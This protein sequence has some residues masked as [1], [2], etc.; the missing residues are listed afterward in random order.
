MRGMISEMAIG[1]EKY[2]SLRTLPSVPVADVV[3]DAVAACVVNTNGTVMGCVEGISV[4][5][6]E[7]AKTNK[8]ISSSLISVDAL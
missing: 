7:P 8:I 5:A 2:I 6:N 1:K 3:G 4:G